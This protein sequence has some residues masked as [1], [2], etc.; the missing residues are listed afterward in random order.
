MSAPDLVR[1][2]PDDW[3][4]FRAVRLA[5]L[6]DAPGAFGARHSEWA[7]ATEERWRRRLTDVP[8]TVVARGVDGPV[9]VVSGVASGESGESVELISMWVAPGERGT[10]LAGR[11]I[12]LVVDWARDGGRRTGLMVRDDNLGAIR[13]YTRAGFVDHGVPDDW[14]ATEPAERRM[15]HEGTPARPRP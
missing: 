7:D 1:I 8:F 12:A 2:G 11:L 6:A 3:R 14:P 13:A 5:A 4:E 15:W 9:G 10:G